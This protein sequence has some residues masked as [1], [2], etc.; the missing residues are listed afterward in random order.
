MINFFRKIRKELAA[1]NN[2][3]KYLRY[4]IGEIILVIIGILIALSINNWNENRKL[5]IEEQN[6]LKDLRTEVAVNIEALSSTI[7]TNKIAY[8]IGQKFDNLFDDR[9]AFDVM[10]DSVFRADYL[11]MIYNSTFDPNMGILNSMISSGKI[12]NISNKELLYLLSSLDD[13]I[14]D[15]LEDQKKIE[16]NLDS[17]LEKI[18]T[19]SSLIING[20][21]QGPNIRLYYDNPRFRLLIK[22][23]LVFYRGRGLN[24]EGKLLAQFKHILELI[25][26][27]IEK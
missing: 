3:V 4:A 7:E 9:E 27:E 16:L 23:F 6:S 25:D 19:S 11:R 5:K 21:N 22:R 8:D 20:Q 15:A 24:E 12:N 18:Y 13:L 17:Y 14:T 10:P 2:V 1:E 26:K